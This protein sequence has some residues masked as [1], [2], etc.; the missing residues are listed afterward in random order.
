MAG[1]AGDTRRRS[2]DAPARARHARAAWSSSGCAVW[3]RRLA[4]RFQFSAPADQHFREQPRAVRQCC[5]SSPTAP[6]TASS[7]SFSGATSSTAIRSMLRT[8]PRLPQQAASP[9]LPV[10]GS[11]RSISAMRS[12]RNTGSLAGGTVAPGP[13]GSSSGPSVSSRSIAHHR[14]ARQQQPAF[15]AGA[16]ESFGHR[17]HGARLGSSSNSRASPKPSS[18]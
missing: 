10:S 18:R 15:P 9:R 14:H 6:I 13:S 1:A 3:A 4:P 2:P 5:E 7:S 11:A 12:R 8:L 16:H 17:A